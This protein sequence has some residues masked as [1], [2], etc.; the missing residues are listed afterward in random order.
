[1]SKLNDILTRYVASGLRA[2]GW[3]RRRNTFVFTTIDGDQGVIR[4]RARSGNIL[5]GFVIEVAIWPEP[6]LAMARACD[7]DET[8]DVPPEGN[9]VMDGKV[10]APGPHAE[11]PEIGGKTWRIGDATQLEALGLA[12]QEVVVRRVAPL[13]TSLLDRERLIAIVNELEPPPTADC[14]IWY[15]WATRTWKLL[16]L[17]ADRGWT[18]AFETELVVAR[19][20]AEPADP[21]DESERVLAEG[22]KRIVAWAEARATQ[23][24]DSIGESR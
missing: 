23:R 5:A 4:F 3:T 16:P 10:R 18:K 8:Q 14:I 15:C 1:M 9:A 20:Y 24:S 6:N 21:T 22:W 19:S 11:D 12:V 17:L 2:A 13:L 7:D